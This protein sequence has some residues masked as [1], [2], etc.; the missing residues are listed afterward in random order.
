ME[1][2]EPRD[3]LHADLRRPGLLHALLRCRRPEKDS[4]VVWVGSGENSSQRS[5]HFGDGVY[6]ST[7]AGETWKNVG[8]QTSEHIGKILVDPRSSNTVYVASQGP[9]WSAGGER[10]LYKTTDGGVT[11]N[12]VLTISPD[13]GISDAVF[14]TKNPDIIYASAYQRRRAVGQ[15]IGGGPE[16]GIFKTTNAGKTWTKL[17]N[18]LP[19]DD[20]GRVALGVDPR[21]PKRVYAL[22][23][24]KGPRGRGGLAQSSRIR[25]PSGP[26]VDEA[27]FIVRTMRARRGN[28]SGGPSQTGTGWKRRRRECAGRARGA[29]CP[30]SA[31]RCGRPARLVSR[32]GAAYYRRFSSIPIVPT[33]STR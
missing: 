31:G 19:K 18:G 27:G 33:R 28:G 13:T 25:F 32:G 10:G 24:A 21:N 4:N 3:H 15:M 23:S 11:W 1:D 26:V 2:H 8:L 17:S 6:K 14:D 20:V 29:R 22:I 12:A 5:A 7:D 30:G 16:G 9:L